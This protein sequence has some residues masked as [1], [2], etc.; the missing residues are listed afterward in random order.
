M[1]RLQEF[2]SIFRGVLYGAFDDAVSW[3]ESLAVASHPL[4][5][6]SSLFADKSS[7][8]PNSF[9]RIAVARGERRAGALQRSTPDSRRSIRQRLPRKVRSRRRQ[10]ANADRLG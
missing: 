10:S 9:N 6:D 2:N 7:S 5:R 1:W 4:Q 3:F 8:F